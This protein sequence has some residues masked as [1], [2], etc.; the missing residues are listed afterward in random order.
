MD[1]DIARRLVDASNLAYGIDATGN[2]FEAKAPYTTLP[3]SIG[4]IP[5]SL[6]CVRPDGID[7]CYWGE[8]SSGD[9]ILS[10]RGTLPPSLMSE[11][12]EMFYDVLLD[13]LNDAKAAQVRGQDLPGLV[14]AGFLGSL[15]AMWPKLDLAAFRAAIADGKR[16]YVTGHSKGGSLAHL[17]AYR[18]VR[19]GISPTAV[20]TFAAARAGNGDF[21]TAYNQVCPATWRFEY[22]DDLV[23]HIPPHTSGWLDALKVH[24]ATATKFPADAPHPT[25]SPTVMA[26]AEALISR[27]DTI[28]LPDYVS[29]GTLEFIDWATPPVLEADS[30]TLSLKREFSLAGKFA[31]FKFEEVAGDHSLTPG[32]AEGASA[33]GGV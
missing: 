7:G 6:H 33:T 19:S 15:D 2:G 10:F 1:P 31:E 8:T 22:R 5:A 12:P 3:A 13:W 14:H 32:Y 30:F 28:D 25:G 21:A 11:S 26:R 24:R 29:V 20:Y 23:P 18:L 17:A 27:L 9:V 16:L 4:F